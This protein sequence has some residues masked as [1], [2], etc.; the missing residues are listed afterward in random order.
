[1]HLHKYQLVLLVTVCSFFI[2]TS[3]L[4][5]TTNAFS[6]ELEQSKSKDELSFE[7]LD[8]VAN[9]ILEQQRIPGIAIVVVK[10]GKTVFKNG[11]GFANLEE[12][13]SVDP[14]RTLFRIGS[15]SKALT[16][17]TL[18]KLID[19]GRLKRSDNVESFIDGI[20]NPLDFD[21]PITID[22]LLTHTAGFD[23]IG[24]GR[25]IYDHDLDLASR[26]AKR[27]NLTDFL[28]ANNLRRVS[29]PGEMFRYDTYGVTL[30]GA[31]IEKV[32]GKP[33]SDAMKAELFLPLGMQNSFVEVEPQYFSD[34]ATGYGWRDEQFQS[35]PYEVYVTTPASSIDSTIA[36]MGR[37]LETLT[38]DGANANGRLLSTKATQRVLS[39]QFRAHPDFVG[40]T[41]GFFESFTSN[42]GRTQKHLPTIGHGG[43]MDGYRSAL[44]VIPDKRVGIFIAANRA[45][46]S[47]G[48]NVDFRP[49]IDFVV[50]QFQDAPLKEPFPIPDAAD[51]LNVDLTEY[52]SDYYYGVFCHS[53][54]MEDAAALSWPRPDA[55]K[56]SVDGDKLLI[57]EETYLPCEKDLFVKADGERQVFFGRNSKGEISNFVYSTSPDTFERE[58]KEL[59][60]REFNSLAQHVFAMATTESEAAAIEFLKETSNHKTFYIREDELNRAGYLLLERDAARVAVELF[61]LNT[62]RFPNS[63]NAFDSLAE[64]YSRSGKRD[65]AIENYKKTLE[66]NADNDAAE[67]RLKE[68]TNQK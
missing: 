48:G 66:M 30:A 52:E 36:D 61:R 16:F 33:F 29:A 65:L 50:E 15:V 68:L 53:P 31:I 56:V 4:E 41:H 12:K 59:P 25:H 60:Y 58:S 45:P 47:G 17:L 28:E 55:R 40:I 39:P 24:V 51:G 2:S 19:D 23:Q 20:S 3:T 10:N 64:A 32:T 8:D 34:L 14:D 38:N 62:I 5:R 43:S 44:T 21:Q 22:H 37:L 54:T 26:K 7:G 9:G 13:I 67:K 42:D 35:R 57:G 1:M 11:Y 27:P 6:N 46:E 49:I 63:W 18:T